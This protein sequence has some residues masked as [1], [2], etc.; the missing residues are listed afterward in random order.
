MCCGTTGHLAMT[1]YTLNMIIILYKLLMQVY[2]LILFC[3]MI[4]KIYSE[5]FRGYLTFPLRIKMNIFLKLLTGIPLPEN[6]RFPWVLMA[7]MF[8]PIFSM[9]HGFLYRYLW[10]ILPVKFIFTFHHSRFFLP[11]LFH[12]MK[13]LNG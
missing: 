3:G 13:P 11:V 4:K 9:I 12:T 8:I 2:S 1:F 7:L 10:I 6:S 5:H